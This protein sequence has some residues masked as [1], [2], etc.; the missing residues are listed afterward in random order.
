GQ[1]EQQKAV[2]Q[3]V[4][5]GDQREFQIA[6]LAGRCRIEEVE[7]LA[8]S[9]QARQDAKVQRSYGIRASLSK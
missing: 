5:E 9:G 3:A 6:S 4:Q 1:Q 7:E 2:A 8:A